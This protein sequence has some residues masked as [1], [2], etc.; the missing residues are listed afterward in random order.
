MLGPFRQVQTTG[1]AAAG[2]ATAR[3]IAAR[4]RARR[5]DRAP[6]RLPLRTDSDSRTATTIEGCPSLISSP[7]LSSVGARTPA[8]RPAP[9]RRLSRKAR[10]PSY[11]FFSDQ[12]CEE[13]ARA[14]EKLAGRSGS[15][16]LSGSRK[17]LLEVAVHVD[18]DV[19][20]AGR[21]V[22]ERH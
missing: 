7:P 3:T 6:I 11:E 18:E 14:R 8:R 9:S 4:K 15:V 22:P 12:A 21:L 5:R 2:R 20:R 10:F 17:R 13:E 19:N 16:R 1:C